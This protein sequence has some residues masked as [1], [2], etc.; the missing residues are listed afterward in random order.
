MPPGRRAVFTLQGRGAIM[1]GAGLVPVLEISLNSRIS[2]TSLSQY[3]DATAVG[4]CP[5]ERQ[6]ILLEYPT[7]GWNKI[8]PSKR[9]QIENRLSRFFSLSIMIKPTHFFL[10]LALL[11][12]AVFIGCN[13][14][15]PV[16]G[17]WNW[18]D[19]SSEIAISFDSDGNYYQAYTFYSPG[20]LSQ[21]AGHQTAPIS[22]KWRGVWFGTYILFKDNG[23]IQRWDYSSKQDIIYAEK[24]KSKIFHRFVY[25]AH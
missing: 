24:D 6:N 16:I 22:G 9:N 25:P 15:A 2:N 20:G 12:L 21:V 1:N 13:Y 4:A 23:D 5:Q 7:A 18:N 14:Q 8:S 19:T 11:Y 3:G 10:V 17:T